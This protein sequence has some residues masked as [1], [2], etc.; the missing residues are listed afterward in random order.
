MALFKVGGSWQGSAVGAEGTRHDLSHQDPFPHTTQSPPS[1]LMPLRVLTQDKA[2]GIEGRQE[3]GQQGA[4][5]SQHGPA[6]QLVTGREAA[7]VGV[8]EY[9]CQVTHRL[10]LPSDVG[11]Q[12]EGGAALGGLWEAAEVGPETGRWI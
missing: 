11:L 9:G 7:H 1:T 6:C 8:P 5:Q 12:A 10:Q 3:V 4:S 2:G